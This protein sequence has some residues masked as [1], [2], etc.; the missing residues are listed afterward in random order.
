M[1]GG[2]R[3][4]RSA[5]QSAGD[6]P[7]NDPGTTP[8]T[9]R[10]DTDRED[11]P[12]ADASSDENF[13][14]SNARATT[15]PVH[16]RRRES[17]E[18]AV[19][20]QAIV[21]KRLEALEE[22]ELRDA[23]IAEIELRQKQLDRAVATMKEAQGGKIP[24]HN[25]PAFDEAGRLMRT[26]N[27][28]QPKP[29]LG[30]EKTSPTPQQVD[31]WAKGI[32]TAF[33][34]TQVLEDSVTRTHWIMGTIQ[35]S[36]HKELIQQRITEG[37]IRTWAQLS[38]V[39]EQLVQDPVFTRYENYQKFFDVEWRKEDSTNSF[40]MLLSRRESL[41][42]RSFFKFDDGTED[43]EFK[44]AFIWSKIPEPL[45]KEIQR[46]GTL[47][48]IQEWS[49][50]ERALRNAETAVGPQKSTSEKSDRQAMGKRGPTSPPRR[51][52]KRQNSRGN[53]PTHSDSGTVP[54]EP[55][56]PSTAPGQN[57]GRWT[58]RGGGNQSQARDH[59]KSHWKNRDQGNSQ[60]KQDQG[61]G[62]P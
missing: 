3:T 43:H 55:R 62:K 25:R 58:S 36:T 34:N 48:H 45:Q 11:N 59:Q 54:G 2:H 39:E 14:P 1:A 49:E 4:L 42:P 5:T 41:L 51:R 32:E 18:E 52:F 53:T 56:Q 35:F 38:T 60:Q 12:L 57:S 40:L 46:N 28:V 15:L 7:L 47:E 6:A 37:S 50:F 61:K 10:D 24:G 27:N 23:P 33:Q 22:A 16:P 20:L 8:E 29:K 26:L 21:A 13:A 17:Q 19:S 44:I 30:T 31:Q 9:R